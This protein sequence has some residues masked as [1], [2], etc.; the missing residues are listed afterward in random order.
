MINPG[1]AGGEVEL[2]DASDSLAEALRLFVQAVACASRNDFFDHPPDCCSACGSDFPTRLQGEWSCRQDMFQW[3][4][5]RIASYPQ[6]CRFSVALTPTPLRE[7]TTGESLSV[8]LVVWFAGPAGALTH[9]TYWSFCRCHE[10]FAVCGPQDWQ[11]IVTAGPVPGFPGPETGIDLTEDPE[12]IAAIGSRLTAHRAGLAAVAGLTAALEADDTGK[13]EAVLKKMTDGENAAWRKTLDQ[14]LLDTARDGRIGIVRLLLDHGGDPEARDS[15]HTALM[16]AA[17]FGHREI[18]RLLLDR[19]API[20]AADRSGKTALMLA[21]RQGHAE[22]V[23]LLIE[24]E[25]GVNTRDQAGS[26]ALIEAAWDGH[27]EVVRLLLAN[28]ADARAQET[29]TGATALWRA[30]DNDY[31]PEEKIKDI[32]RMLAN[33]GADPN[34]RDKTGKTPLMCAERHDRQGLVDLLKRIGARY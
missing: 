21:A 23:R 26:S 6:A 9:A 18:V 16:K 22:I 31:S 27:P 25:A 24:R 1:P 15:E 29:R 34:V 20:D 12:Q 17:Y 5:K 3:M 30:A 33:A 14:A 13:I 2:L 10:G 32:V 19:G 8:Q 7:S 4:A 11:E 28:K